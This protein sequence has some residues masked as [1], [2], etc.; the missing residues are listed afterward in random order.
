MLT[1]TCVQAASDDDPSPE[2]NAGPTRKRAFLNHHGGRTCRLR[3]RT[4]EAEVAEV[5][6]AG[7]TS[8][9]MGID[10][11]QDLVIGLFVRDVAGLTSRPG[12]SACRASDASRLAPTLA[13]ASAK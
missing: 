11:P 1:S 7:R 12:A 5:Q 8:W 4:F 6:E 9:R 10:E 3:L 2:T 13:I